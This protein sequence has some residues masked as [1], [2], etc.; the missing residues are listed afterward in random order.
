MR[1]TT[2]DERKATEAARRKLA[3]DGVVRELDA[4]ARKHGGRFIV[5]GSFATDTMRFDSDLDVMI[6]FP[7]D[8][9]P[10]AWRFVEDACARHEVPLD[11]HDARTTKP[12]FVER[13]CS[14]GLVLS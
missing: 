8:R 13:V 4:Y 3:A 11:A 7:A 14:R 6:D 10:D 9:T 2:L 1:V 12:G 5:F